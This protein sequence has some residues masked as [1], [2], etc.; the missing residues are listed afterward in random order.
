MKE[1]GKVGGW[2]GGGL[3]IEFSAVSRD[4]DGSPPLS[5]LGIY[6]K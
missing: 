3:G 6:Y 5:R 1:V 2:I 4:P